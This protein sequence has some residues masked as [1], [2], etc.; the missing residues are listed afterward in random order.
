[1][2]ADAKTRMKQP[3]N[4]A[5]FW[6]P[7]FAQTQVLQVTYLT[8]ILLTLQ[9]LTNIQHLDV[10]YYSGCFNSSIKDYKTRSGYFRKVIWF[11]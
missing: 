4:F 11:T 5:E 2:A 9:T 6:S 1:V 8:F 3:R 10:I 7:F